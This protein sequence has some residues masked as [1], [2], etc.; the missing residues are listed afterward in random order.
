MNDL[1]LQDLNLKWEELYDRESDREVYDKW[2]EYMHGFDDDENFPVALY[3]LL[4]LQQFDFS[5]LEP[6]TVIGLN[7]KEDRY[8]NSDIVIWTGQEFVFPDTHLDDYGSMPWPVVA[9]TLVSFS[10][11]LDHNAWTWLDVDHYRDELLENIEYDDV[12]KFAVTSLV[13]HPSHAGAGKKFYVILADSSGLSNEDAGD[14]LEEYL[15]KANA[16]PVW[17][18]AHPEFGGELIELVSSDYE[19]PDE[20]DPDYD[21]KAD[22]S[23]ESRQAKLKKTLAH[24]GKGSIL[25]ANTK[26]GYID[27]GDNLHR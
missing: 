27:R 6:G 8:R 22:L 4:E 2:T 3:D 20:N 14:K 26:W 7:S 9:P 17:F 11:Y 16:I 21:W 18:D 19:Y 10:D 1:S 23:E 24:Y 13:V 25:L 5:V 15:R 12:D